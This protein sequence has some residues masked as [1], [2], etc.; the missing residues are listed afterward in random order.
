MQ[1]ET[2]TE[3]GVEDFISGA[4]EIV[5]ED[6]KSKN[7]LEREGIAQKIIDDDKYDSA[8]KLMDDGLRED[9]PLYG[10]RKDFLAAYIGDHREKF[11]EIWIC[12][13][14]LSEW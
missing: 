1:T 13:D 8:C 10:Y 12:A 7:R 9:M 11:E 4:A 5:S 6:G 2:E 14:P 3:T